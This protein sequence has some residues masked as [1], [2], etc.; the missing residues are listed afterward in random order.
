M[1]PPIV[2]APPLFAVRKL[3]PGFVVCLVTDFH[4]CVCVCVHLGLFEFRYPPRY[5]HFWTP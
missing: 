4:V 3:P 1:F 5:T 2:S